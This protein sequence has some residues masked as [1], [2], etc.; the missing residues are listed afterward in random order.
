MGCD[1]H[2]YIEKRRKDGTWV[3]VDDKHRYYKV[4]YSKP[5]K[6]E[7]VTSKDRDERWKAYEAA[8]SRLSD[9]FGNR[10]YTLFAALA[11][12]RNYGEGHIEPLFAGRGMP[13]DA[14]NKTKREIPEEDSDYHSHTFFTLA[15]LMAVDPNEVAQANGSVCLY[16]AQYQEWKETGKVPEGAEAY[17]LGHE[18][19]QAEMNLLLLAEEP[20]KHMRKSRLG[21]KALEGPY[22]RLGGVPRTYKELVPE[23][24]EA[25][26]IMKGMTKDPEALRVVIAFDN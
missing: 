22:V 4:L 7:K 25:I 13:E 16:P 8:R 2:P 18:V 9:I 14:A 21:G 23:L 26:D 11:D 24:F 1:S 6:G 3:V 5:E 10:N 20:K 12:V 15:E 17:A 19:E